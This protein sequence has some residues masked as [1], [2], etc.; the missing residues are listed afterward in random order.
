M[1][2]MKNYVAPNMEILPKSLGYVDNP[3]PL[4]EKPESSAQYCLATKP[5]WTMRY[6]NVTA[7]LRLRPLY[8]QM[9]GYIFFVFSA[10]AHSALTVNDL[11]HDHWPHENPLVILYYKAGDTQ[12]IHTT[13]L[14]FLTSDD[15]KSGYITHYQTIPT[16]KAFAIKPSQAFALLASTTYQA[17]RAVLTPEKIGLIHSVLLRFHGSHHELP[18]FL[19]GCADEGINCCLSIECSNEAGVCLPKYAFPRQSFIFFANYGSAANLPYF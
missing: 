17:A 10:C 2:A 12:S 11:F 5:P 7:G 18:R 8:Q 14:V 13:Q 9:L 15:C 3:M 16:T 4:E 6:L 1:G 19:S